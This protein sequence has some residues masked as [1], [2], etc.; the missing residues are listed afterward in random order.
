MRGT[1]LW[2]IGLLALAACGGDSSPRYAEQ[3][4]ISIISGDGQQGMVQE[5]QQGLLAAADLGVV[6]PD[7]L[8]ARIEDSGISAS[9]S[10]LLTPQVSFAPLPP[11][12][13]VEYRIS[14]EGCGQ[15]WISSVVP[16]ELGDVKTLWEKPGALGS[17]LEYRDG[18]WARYCDLAMEARV[19]IGGQF[20]VD[21]AFSAVFTPS[22]PVWTNLAGVGFTGWESLTID[23]DR[24]R[25]T[26]GNTVHWLLRPDPAL[27]ARLDD[28]EGA[29]TLVPVAS[30]SGLVEVVDAAGRTLCS[31]HLN[32]DGSNLQVDFYDVD[33]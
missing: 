7:T 28:V 23:Q 16:D 31:G 17:E 25:D 33:C 3:V 8:V 4:K 30:G 15:P 22:D 6:L 13:S 21:T 20:K 9:N 18:L 32:V 12:T 14:A 5:S 19:F 10:D 29:R 11:G 1:A 27:A 26:W 2:I 24:V